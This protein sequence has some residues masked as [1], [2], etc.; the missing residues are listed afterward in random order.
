MTNGNTVGVTQTYQAV[1]IL[2]QAKTKTSSYLY[3]LEI[4]IKST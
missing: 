3:C 4:H 1:A 2:F